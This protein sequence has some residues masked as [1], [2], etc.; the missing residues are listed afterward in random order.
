MAINDARTTA[1]EVL[2][3]IV[4]V[5]WLYEKVFWKLLDKLVYDRVIDDN[6]HVLRN[7]YKLDDTD[8]VFKRDIERREFRWLSEIV[9]KYQRIN[10]EENDK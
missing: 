9:F 7:I 3:K 8:E 10:N 1:N 5:E 6:M 2:E 4:S